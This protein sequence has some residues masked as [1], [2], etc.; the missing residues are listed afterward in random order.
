MF[1]SLIIMEIVDGNET[2]ADPENAAPALRVLSE[3]GS[4]GNTPYPPM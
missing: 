4:S 3:F 1:K 2:E